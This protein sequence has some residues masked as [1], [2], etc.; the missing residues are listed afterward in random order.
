M[1][2]RSGASLFVPLELAASSSADAYGPVP[3]GVCWHPVLEQV[4]RSLPGGSQR[5]WGIPF[6][7]APARSTRRWIWLTPERPA[8]ALRLDQPVRASSLVVAHFATPA[9]ETRSATT[10]F[11]TG[12]P[13]DPGRHLADY[14]VRTRGGTETTYPI[15]LRFEI[16][17]V[18]V[19]WGQLPF[20]A[21]PHREA[22]KLDPAGPHAPGGWGRDQTGAE[23]PMY[24]GIDVDRLTPGIIGNYWLTTLSL[25]ADA[26]DVSTISLRLRGTTPVAVAG[27]TAS[28]A[29]DDPLVRRSARMALLQGASRVRLDL[30]LGVVARDTRVRAT[31]AAWLDDPAAGLGAEPR[32][33]GDRLIEFTSSHDASITVGDGTIPIRHLLGGRPIRVGGA[34]I[35]LLP[36]VDRP[37]RVRVIDETTGRPTP[38]RVHFRTAEGR[39]LPP[40]GHPREVGTGWFEDHGPD[41]RL[42]SMDYAYVDGQCVVRCPVG[43]VYAEV[44]KGFELEPV[45]RAVEVDATTDELELVLRRGVQ[46]QQQGWLTADTH[47]HFV[48]PETARI[49]GAAE[50]VD[51]VNLLVAK[52]GDLYTNVGDFAGT[53]QG[54]DDGTIV[55]VGSENRHHFL[56]HL[57]LLGP[58]ALVHPLSAGGPN[59][60]SLGEETGSGFL[61]SWADQAR[62]AGGLAVV[63]HFPNPYSE[64]VAAA[65]L[66]RIDA[67]EI[68]DFTWGLDS[69]GVAEWYRLLNVGCRIPAVGGTDKMSAG[70][71]IGG[72]RTYADIGGEARSF[73]AFKKAVRAGRTFT[74]SGPLV[75][76][77]VDGAG[78]GD[79]KSVAGR[80][81]LEVSA[82][83]ESIY[84]L[85]SLELVQDGRVVARADAGGARFAHVSLRLPVGRSRWI[86]ARVSSPVRAWH[87]WPILLAAHTS[88][89]YLVGG[90]PPAPAGDRA[91]L[92]TILEGSLVWIDRVGQPESATSL[93]PLR[94]SLAQA[95]DVLRADRPAR[96]TRAGS[97]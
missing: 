21:R 13:D 31:T 63:P 68:K 24:A 55:R 19:G 93:E 27:L 76:L 39:Y 94:R 72:I 73:D 87:V 16:M 37:V 61:G 83:A 42:G 59:E 36:P 79:E 85:G 35:R 32:A 6:R 89:V 82:R 4:L 46:W 38:A 23:L 78:P 77:D 88:P 62:R 69:F 56:G 44:S 20:A 81:H 45:R 51:L 48:S 71:P 26:E 28:R 57:L 9:P 95:M 53:R 65:L 52:W 14:M 22:R 12:R 54:P 43:T 33:T 74:T 3:T 50:G 75:A 29:I 92:Q 15:R 67:V 8:V 49:E 70:M 34:R 97:S 2:R 40:D 96:A 90:R 66:G 17:D 1:R 10:G 91:F 30:D 7:L 60:A 47:V 86:A 41:L 84:P 18:L 80:T 58:D 11:P 25:P 64:V 5:F